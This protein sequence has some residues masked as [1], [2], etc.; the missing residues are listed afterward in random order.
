MKKFRHILLI[1]AGILAGII[2]FFIGKADLAND[3]EKIVLN[4]EGKDYVL[5][6]ARTVLQRARGLSGISELKG[7]DGMVF[8]FAPESK[9]T[10]WNKNTHLDLELIWMSGDEIIGRDLLV[11]EDK[12]GL[13]TITAPAGIDKVIELVK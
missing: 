2:L 5:Y 1:A 3:A 4:I 6:T 8:F 10:F 9:P 13:I 11:S 7:A 12:T